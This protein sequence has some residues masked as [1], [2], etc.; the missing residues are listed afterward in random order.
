MPMYRASNVQYEHS[1]C[2]RGLTSGGIG[3]MHRLALWF[4]RT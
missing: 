1:D 2:V 4:A 3:A